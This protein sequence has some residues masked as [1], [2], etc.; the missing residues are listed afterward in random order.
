MALSWT[1]LK[2]RLVAAIGLASAVFLVGAGMAAPGGAA[3]PSATKPA[4]AF[5][6]VLASPLDAPRP[7]LATDDRRHL[8]YELHS[9]MPSG[10]K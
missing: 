5:T 10:W 4:Q 3:P 1:R 9:P 6:V 8:V 2:N 7:V